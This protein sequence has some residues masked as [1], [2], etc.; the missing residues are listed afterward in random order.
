MAQAEYKLFFDNTPA[1]REQLDR[2]ET[3]TVEQQVD[4]AFEA[5]LD[6]LIRTDDDGNWKGTEDKFMAGFGR[7][8][9]EVRIGEGE[10][11]PLIDGS[12]VGP[13]TTTDAKPGQSLITLVVHDDSILLNREE[14]V[15]CFENTSDSAIAKQVFGRHAE[16][17]ETRIEDVALAGGSRPVEVMRKGTHMDLLRELARRNDMHVCVL[18]GAEPGKSIGVFDSFPTEPEDLP[19]LILTGSDRNMESFTLRKNEQLPAVVTASTLNLSDKSII[20]RESDLTKVELLGDEQTF[21]DATQTGRRQLPPGDLSTMDLDN[22]VNAESRRLSFAF[23]ASGVVRA[24]CYSGVLQP[25]RVVGICGVG[26]SSSGLYLLT[27]VTHTLTRSDYTQSFSCLR[28]AR[29]RAAGGTGGA[30]GVIM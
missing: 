29:S 18:P 2:V 17:G 24:G 9:V 11:V 28:N 22:R 13:A 30:A 7:V 1:T 26:P 4:Q 14:G 10:F 25:Y 12:I 5:R 3:V 16:I 20:T 19:K 27:S 6:L 21:D 15:E 8:R 23:D